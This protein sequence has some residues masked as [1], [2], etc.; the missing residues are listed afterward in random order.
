VAG[1]APEDDDGIYAIN[2][3]PLVDVMLVL[4]I[5]FLVTS[6]YIV[7]PSIEAN[8]P[9]AAS[10]G[11]AL[12]TTL[13]LVLKADGSLFMNGEPATEAQIIE[14]C[15]KATA[16]DP[17]VQAIIAADA[18]TKYDKV[19]RLIDLVKTNGVAGFALNI[20]PAQRGQLGY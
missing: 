18:D 8:L 1:S 13:S 15:H 19:V 17:N 12:D 16:R 9:K 5:I 6:T 7:K 20:D 3:T 4:L 2:V 10:A 14:Q 11:D